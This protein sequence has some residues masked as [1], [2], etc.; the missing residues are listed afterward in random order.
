MSNNEKG[1]AAPS[2]ENFQNTYGEPNQNLQNIGSRSN[3]EVNPQY[4]GANTIGDS[5]P[6]DNSIQHYELPN[7]TQCKL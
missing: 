1:S 2:E 7:L 5:I 3:N 4:Q 6:I